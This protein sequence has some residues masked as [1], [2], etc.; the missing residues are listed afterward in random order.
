MSLTWL[1]QADEQDVRSLFNWALWSL[2]RTCPG[3]RSGV[4]GLASG[5]VVELV[6]PLGRGA[7]QRCDD[8]ADVEPQGR[9]F[10]AGDDAALHPAPALCSVG[11]LAVGP[12]GGEA[13]LGSH[14]GTGVGG[15]WIVFVLSMQAGSVRG[16][17][18]ACG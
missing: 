3:P 15:P 11:R 1:A 16:L 2:T 14:D 12:E 7:S 8:G 6:E 5:V 10:D 13:L 17:T 18:S 9:R 4:F